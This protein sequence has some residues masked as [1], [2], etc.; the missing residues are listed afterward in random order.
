MVRPLFQGIAAILAA[1]PILVVVNG[2]PR[3]PG[4]RRI[5][6]A[7][8]PRVHELGSRSVDT[9]R[10]HQEIAPERRIVA[11]GY[12]LDAFRIRKD[13]LAFDQFGHPDWLFPGAGTREKFLS[14]VIGKPGLWDAG[15][16]A[17][18]GVHIRG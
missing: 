8:A 12:A 9:N 14:G 17:V 11:H 3:A 7:E 6:D 2:A 16:G 15:P 5:E 4:F 10:R 1:G 13:A 18:P